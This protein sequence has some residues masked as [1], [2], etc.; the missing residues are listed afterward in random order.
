MPIFRTRAGRRVAISLKEAQEQELQPHYSK[1][2]AGEW[3]VEKIDIHRGGI[4]L[5]KPNRFRY[6][7]HHWDTFWATAFGEAQNSGFKSHELDLILHVFSQW[8]L[9]RRA[10]ELLQDFRAGRADLITA[11]SKDPML[12]DHP[13]MLR[14]VMEL[15]VSGGLPARRPGRPAN[16]DPG[17][18]ELY[19]WA[20]WYYVRESISLDEACARAVENHPRHVPA[21]WR[22][23]AAGTLKRNFARFD[24][25][26]GHSTKAFR[27]QK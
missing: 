4:E 10:Q 16:P 18:L 19:A 12:Q 21:S 11:L 3:L 27:G 23:D 1:N 22:K 5:I 25:L 15:S 13:A 2:E 9:N 17:A 7:P 8:D 14:E 20:S 24:A 6:K 26:P